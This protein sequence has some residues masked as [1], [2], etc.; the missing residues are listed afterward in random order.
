[1]ELPTQA[2]EQA[3][4]ANLEYANA[5][6]RSCTRRQ[7]LRGYI[8]GQVTYNLGGYPSR[9]SIM[10]TEYDEE[11]IRTLAQMGVG[12]IQVH[13]EWN[14]SIRVLGADKYSS[15]DPKGMRAFVELCHRWGIKI[16]PYLSTGYIDARDP[17]CREEFF[18]T[19]LRLEQMHFRYR[20]ASAASAAWCSFILEKI[21]RVL[22]EYGVDGIY[23][24]YGYAKAELYR[25]ECVKNGVPFREDQ[26]PYD[27]YMEDLL[28]QVYTLINERNGVVKLHIAGNRRPTTAEKVYDYLW[29]GEGITDPST[30]LMTVPYDPFVVPCPDY[31]CTTDENFESFFAQTLPFLQFPLRLDGRPLNADKI[32]APGVEYAPDPMT[33]F[34]VAVADYAQ[35]HPNGPYV[36]SEWSAIPDNV[37]Q[38]RR[39]ETYLK[40]YLPMVKDN[41]VCHLNVRESTLFREPM[42]QKVYMSLFSG[43][44]QYLCISN[45]DTKPCTLTPEELWQDCESR[46]KLNVLTLQPQRVRFLK[47][48]RV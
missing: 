33:D 9:F 8:P 22:E 42:P 21:E 11:R 13:E 1:M 35:K 47:R 15:H 34:Y 4:H 36:Y 26:L 2:Q 32:H 18:D 37:L 5:S 24:D 38:R 17:F 16:V 3:R 30:M 23:N 46:Q 41:T 10:P 27:P 43:V 39:W 44:E 25:R 7:R 40:L 45:L 48:L 14:D 29:V 19:D 31:K 20:H 6:V 12:L 28:A